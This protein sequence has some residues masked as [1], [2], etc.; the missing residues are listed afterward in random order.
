M[1]ICTEARATLSEA[2]PER[3]TVPD[4]LLLFAGAVIAADGGV[5]S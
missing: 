4:A 1:E 5:V 3:V 2:V